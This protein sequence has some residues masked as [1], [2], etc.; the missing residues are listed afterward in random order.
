MTEGWNSKDPLAARRK[1][2]LFRA[3]RRG[4]RESDMLIGGFA[5]E[6][7]AEL[8]EAQIE[9]F[10]ALLEHNDPEVL[11]WIVGVAPVPAE[12]DHDVMA[13]LKSY[14]LSLAGN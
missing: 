14:R 3:Q 11:S 12:F 1:R 6:H 5:R 13:L 7:L 8:D 10:E 4:T 9:R 2:C